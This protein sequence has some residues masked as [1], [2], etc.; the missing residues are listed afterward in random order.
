MGTGTGFEGTFT[1]LGERQ[2]LTPS[3]YRLVLLLF[4]ICPSFSLF[5]CLCLSPFLSFYLCFYFLIFHTVSSLPSCCCSFRVWIWTLLTSLQPLLLSPLLRSVI[6]YTYGG[7]A[8]NERTAWTSSRVLRSLY[9]C[10]SLSVSNPPLSVSLSPTH[11]LTHLSQCLMQPTPLYH[12]STSSS[13]V[14]HVHHLS[15]SHLIFISAI[16]LKQNSSSSFT[17]LP[18]PYILFSTSLFHPRSS[19]LLKHRRS[20]W[21]FYPVVSVFGGLGLQSFS[22]PDVCQ[23]FPPSCRKMCCFPWASALNLNVH[24]VSSL[25]F[26]VP[27][28][29]WSPQS[30]IN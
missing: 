4:S 18:P 25:H 19:L 24:C 5:L 1:L 26:A 17:L 15:F 21:P 14:Q 9:L 30:I 28:S 16:N 27:T 29:K 12:L 2:T 6:H 20:S 22:H 8:A 3:F 7:L 11:C 13:N 23:S 10:L